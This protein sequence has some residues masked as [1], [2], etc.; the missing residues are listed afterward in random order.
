MLK[1]KMTII[2]VALLCFSGTSMGA[3]NVGSVVG[4]RGT[5]VVSRAGETLPL[6]VKDPVEIK[7]TI[8]TGKRSRAKM[9]FI[10]ESIL[11]LASDSKASVEKFIYS[12]EEGGVSIFKLLDG[13]MR[14]VVGKTEFEVHTP[15]AVAA[16]RGTVIEF[17]V[18]I[19]NGKPFTTIIC[20]EGSVKVW[21]TDPAIVGHIKLV[22]GETITIFEGFPLPEPQQYEPSTDPESEEVIPPRPPIERDPPPPGSLPG[23]K[24]QPGPE[25]KPD[26]KP[27]GVQTPVEDPTPPVADN[28]GKGKGPKN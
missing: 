11:T 1:I 28:P 2:S 27:P 5:A 12:R 4:L 24:P 15:T 3:A 17:I 16:A 20:L 8:E 19:M 10:D 6:K 23:P 14:A 22:A 18:G 13:K 9:L 7:D 25:P 26:P 21:G